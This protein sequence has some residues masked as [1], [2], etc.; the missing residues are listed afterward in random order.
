MAPLAVHDADPQVRIDVIE[1]LGALKDPATLPTL[2]QAFVDPSVAQRQAAA[3]AILAVGGKPAVDTLG[4]LANEG[5]VES[6]RFAVV[7]LMTLN[8]PNGAV[9]LQQLGKTHPDEATR[10]LINN[11]FPKGEH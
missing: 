6:Q 2:E 11:G 10:D 4:R 1:A 5:S 8:D 3:R 9:I 7:V